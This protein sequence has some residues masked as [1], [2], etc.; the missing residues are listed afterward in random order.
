MSSALFVAIGAQ[1]RSQD[2]QKQKVRSVKHYYLV[3]R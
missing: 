1:M 3:V 2:S